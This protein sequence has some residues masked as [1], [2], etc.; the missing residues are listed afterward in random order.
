[1]LAKLGA[2]DSAGRVNDTGKKMLAH[3]LHP[4]VARMLIEAEARGAGR[5]GTTLAAILSER[6]IRVQSRARFS[7]GGRVDDRATEDSDAI[8]MLDAF[9]EARDAGFSRHVINGLGLDA[10]AVQAADRARVA[11][12]RGEKRL[13][14][15][16]A[17]D[18]DDALCIAILAGFPDRVTRRKRSGARDLIMPGFGPAELAETSVVRHATFMCAIDATEQRAPGGKGAPRPVVRVASGIDPLHILELFPERVKERAAVTF[19]T[20]KERVVGR[21]EL[22]YEE[23]VIDETPVDVRSDPRAKEELFRAAWQKGA[24]TI[25]PEGE[26]DRWLRRARF[27]AAQDA[28]VVAPTDDDLRAMLMDACDGRASFAELREAGFYDLVVA[29]TKGK[30]AVEKIA[31][32][33][34][35]LASGRTTRVEYDDDKPPW[36]ESYLQDFC[37]TTE[38]PRAGRVPIVLHLLAPNRR[39]VQVT[40]DLAGFW[41]RHYPQIRKEL[42]RRY[43]RHAWPEDPRTV[44]VEAKRR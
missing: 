16:T 26:L 5:S 8:A 4:R 31:P 38:S 19:D 42:M 17:K 3:A 1:L 37:G 13:A 10:R 7:P 2:L 40:T 29:Q 32:D 12:E 35:R 28:S 9:E 20:E 27:A 23:L 6:D 43:P 11:M 30:A 34:I 25:A 21:T 33:R 44:I 36:I 18:R 22:V 24:R 39:A 14:E 41:D 15:D